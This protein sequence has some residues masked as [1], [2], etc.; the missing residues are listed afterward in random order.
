MVVAIDG[1]AGSGKST[2]AK[3]LAE[4]LNIT[5]LNSG[6]FYR[7]I[8][9]A[10]I[11]ANIDFSSEQAILDCAK[12][13]KLEYKNSHLILNDEDVE[14]LLHSD[15]VDA[16][17]AQVSAIVSIRHLVNARLHEITKTLSIV[18]EGRDMTT[19]VF[20]DADYKF[21]LDASPKARALRRFNQGVSGLSL[22]EIEESIKKRDEIDR[23]KKEGSLIISPDAYYFDTSDLTI[24]QVCGTL[25]DKI[26]S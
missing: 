10:L 8:T 17:V 4:K 24:N 3:M 9:L 18:C 26:H 25:I 2:I 15:L 13:Q 19:V 5:F 23:N 16:H 11:R 22:Q 12:A 14:S 1:P 7:A 21:F 6:S 20:P